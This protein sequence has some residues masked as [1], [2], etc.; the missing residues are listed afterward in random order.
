MFGTAG[1]S[2]CVCAESPGAE[3]PHPTSHPLCLP[4]G[5]YC[6]KPITVG[7]RGKIGAPRH[8]FLP[9]GD[10]PGHLCSQRFP[11]LG[12]AALWECWH[13]VHNHLLLGRVMG[14]LQNPAK[15]NKR[16]LSLAMHL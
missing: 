10:S 1:L 2:L 8:S 5:I 6:L 12:M 3:I 7:K 9:Q 15:E 4:I 14:S 13:T 11:Q 16:G